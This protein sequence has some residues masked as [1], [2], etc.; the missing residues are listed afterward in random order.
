MRPLSELEA[1]SIPRDD[2]NVDL[3]KK[4][5]MPNQKNARILLNLSS[6]RLKSLSR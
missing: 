1:N 5:Q 3:V 4:K 2:F 6:S